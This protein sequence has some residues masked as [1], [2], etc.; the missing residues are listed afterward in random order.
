MKKLLGP[1]LIALLLL[2]LQACG[3]QPK[4]ETPPVQQDVEEPRKVLV[5]EVEKVEV[6]FQKQLLP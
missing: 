3:S 4:E 2:S 5:D 1:M 6:K